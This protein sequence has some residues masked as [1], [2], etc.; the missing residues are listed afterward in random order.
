L[1]DDYFLDD[2]EKTVVRDRVRNRGVVCVDVGLP[3]TEQLGENREG[4]FGDHE[5]GQTG[6]GEGLGLPVERRHVG[7]VGNRSGFVGFGRGK[8]IS[9][10]EL[11]VSF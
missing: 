10:G 3:Y 7:H 5:S 6:V 1:V 2:A 11:S 8:N 9:P 4:F